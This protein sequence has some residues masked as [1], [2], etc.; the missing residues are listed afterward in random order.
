MSGGWP[1]TLNVGHPAPSRLQQRAN[2]GA[3]RFS[4]FF[5]QLFLKLWEFSKA[6]LCFGD[7]G[8]KRVDSAIGLLTKTGVRN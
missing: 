2:R 5:L 4:N 1:F 7:E 8:L 3:G 6:L